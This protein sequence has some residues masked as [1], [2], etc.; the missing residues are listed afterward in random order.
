MPLKHGK[1]ATLQSGG[2]IVL[3]A[4]GSSS[5]GK[6]DGEVCGFAN[7]LAVQ[8]LK[9]WHGALMAQSWASIALE[10]TSVRDEESKLK[11]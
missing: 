8:L 2:G 10:G 11:A 4:S 9:R 7:E 1:S 3:G 5:G 6:R